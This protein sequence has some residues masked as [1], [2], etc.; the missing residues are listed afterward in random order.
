MYYFTIRSGNAERDCTNPT[1]NKWYMGVFE[2]GKW[3]T[4]T[5]K[6]ILG[7]NILRV[8]DAGCPNDPGLI[9]PRR[10]LRN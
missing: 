8:L 3:I 1:I 5:E 6:I 2:D 4:T 10:Q 9:G 7:S